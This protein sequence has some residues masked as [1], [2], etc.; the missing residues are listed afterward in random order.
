MC[1]GERPKVHLFKKSKIGHFELQDG[2]TLTAGDSPSQQNCAG[3][4]GAAQE[5][6]IKAKQNQSADRH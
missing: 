3:K 2:L 1:N 6:Y 5:L 4:N